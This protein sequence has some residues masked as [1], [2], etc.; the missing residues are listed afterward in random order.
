MTRPIF[1][2]FLLLLLA[3]LILLRPEAAAIPISPP[4]DVDPKRPSDSRPPIRLVLGDDRSADWFGSPES[5]E[6]DRNGDIYVVDSHNA[7]LGKVGRDGRLAWEIDGREWGGEGFLKPG[8]IGVSSGLSLYLL[9]TGRREIFRISSRGEVL[10]VIEE[11]SLADPR[12]LAETERGKLVIYDAETAEVS[13]W[14]P[15]GGVLWSFRPSGFRSRSRVGMVLLGE[16][17]IC[18][19][20]RGSKTMRIYHFMGGLKRVWK[21]VLPDGSEPRIWSVDFDAGG[22]AGI[23]DTD[24]PGLYTFDPLGNPPLDLSDLLKE[25]D[26]E[27]PGEVC[28]HQEALYLSDSRGGKLYEIRI[29][30]AR[31]GSSP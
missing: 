4:D 24:H 23:L 22:R 27:G 21:P 17:D 5:I 11:D 9:D 18:L 20:T 2:Q 31:S 16:E 10:G 29:P 7:R 12:A 30:A 28:W 15:T 3:P 19:Y 13:V 6:I 1:K 8:T 26:F 25:I 14:G